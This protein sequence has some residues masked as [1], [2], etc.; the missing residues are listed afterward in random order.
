[1]YSGLC[2]FRNLFSAAST[3]R[4]GTRLALLTFVR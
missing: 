4:R 1:M 3:M 2:F